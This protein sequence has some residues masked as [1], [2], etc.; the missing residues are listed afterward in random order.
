MGT[1]PLLGKEKN[2]GKLIIA[3]IHLIRDEPYHVL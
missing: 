1:Y 2:L 3:E